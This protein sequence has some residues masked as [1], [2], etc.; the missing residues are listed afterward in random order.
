[1]LV[2]SVNNVSKLTM[3]L[4]IAG[5]ALTAA[6]TVEASPPTCSPGDYS[7]HA[8]MNHAS[9]MQRCLDSANWRNGYC[10]DPSAEWP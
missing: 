10:P 1:M 3:I 6:P 8:L 9:C 2:R 5:L 4:L 7:D